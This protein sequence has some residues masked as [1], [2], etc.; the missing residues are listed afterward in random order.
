M[1][2]AFS[3]TDWEW[4]FL[5][6]DDL[7]REGGDLD[8]AVAEKAYGSLLVLRM[9]YTAIPVPGGYFVNVRGDTGL[10]FGDSDAHRR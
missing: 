7:L 9:E 8:A 5:S 1:S 10:L 4:V 2:K 3:V 6:G